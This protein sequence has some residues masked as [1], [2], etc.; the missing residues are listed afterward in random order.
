MFLSSMMYEIPYATNI[1]CNFLFFLNE[2]L[3]NKSKASGLAYPVNTW[4]SL[5]STTGISGANFLVYV[6]LVLFL[7]TSLIMFLLMD[8]M[9]N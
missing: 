5:L 7:V 3:M 4:E 8:F 1:T 6:I 9:N 2:N